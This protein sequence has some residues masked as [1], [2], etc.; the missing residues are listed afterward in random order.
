MQII[1]TPPPKLDSPDARTNFV[2][3]QQYLQNT[4]ETIDFI[5][6]K[7]AGAL[8]IV[9]TDGV[10][11]KIKEVQA[12]IVVLDRSV[13]DLKNAQNTAEGNISALETT[14]ASISNSI[15]SINSNINSINSTLSNHESRIS[16]L[17]NPGGGA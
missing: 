4:I 5:L 2:K 7:Y 9:D 16:A 17:E 3:I 8:E 6:A 1:Q 14:V 13:T 15:T 10:D 11:K 12:Q